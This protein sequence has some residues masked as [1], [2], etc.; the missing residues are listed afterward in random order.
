MKLIKELKEEN[1]GKYLYDL[2]DGKS[3]SSIQIV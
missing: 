2:G 1:I 3:V